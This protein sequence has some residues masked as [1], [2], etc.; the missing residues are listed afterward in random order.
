MAH[1]TSV[2]IDGELYEQAKG[3]VTFR[4]AME[5]GIKAL[6][7]SLP[8]EDMALKMKT[9]RDQLRARIDDMRAQ[10]NTIES[11]ALNLFGEPLDQ[12]LCGKSDPMTKNMD[13]FLRTTWK[14]WKQRKSIQFNFSDPAD[15][16]R[17]YDEILTR[18]G[19]T[20]QAA[21]VDFVSRAKDHYEQHKETFGR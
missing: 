19:L 9:E 17:C 12:Y 10:I 2:K 14:P 20:D 1:M 16:A 11:E 8:D 4:E 3:R 6:L 18:Y 7:G 15:V 5:Y 13:D 21:R